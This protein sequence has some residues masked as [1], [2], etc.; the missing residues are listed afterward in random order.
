[1]WDMLEINWNKIKLSFNSNE[2][3]LPQIITIKMQHKIRVRRMINNET[4]NFHIISVYLCITYG[5]VIIEIY[6]CN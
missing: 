2:I 3:E 4:K 6:S 5:I 1:M